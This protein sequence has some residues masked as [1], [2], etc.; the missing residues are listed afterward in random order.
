MFASLTADDLYI[1]RKLFHLEIYKRSGQDF[2][3]LFSKVMRLHNNEF[4]QVKPQGQFGDRKNDGFI[5]STGAYFQIYSPENPAAR[6]KETIDKL[7]TDFA[8]LYS[9]WNL[10]VTPVKEF[11]FVL[12][13]KFQGA[14][15]SLHSELTKIELKYPGV[16]CKPF[17][18][19]HLED[20]FLNLQHLHIIDILGKIPSAEEISLNVSVL[21]EVVEHLIN[22]KEGYRQES[23]PSNPDFEEKISF[24][25]LSSQVATFLRYGSYQDGALKEYFKLN[26]TFTKEDLKNTFNNLYLE[27]A[28][29]IS[30]SQEK[31]DLVFFHIAENAYAVKEKVYQDAVFVLMAYFFSYCD[32]FEEPPI[33]RQQS[34]FDDIAI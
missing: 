19:Q 7:V 30:D 26:S 6:E 11:N 31:N 8:G 29:N 23:I 1:A 15:A 27:G 33:R 4:I 2:E 16:K 5:K 21:N 13:D 20:I 9:Y 14:Y 32:I 24:N 25:S 3:N 12:N 18:S 10:Q 34:L 17:L 22:L 28:K